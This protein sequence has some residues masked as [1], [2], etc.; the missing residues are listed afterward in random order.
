MARSFCHRSF[1]CIP[2]FC[3]VDEHEIEDPEILRALE[4]GIRLSLETQEYHPVVETAQSG[5]YEKAA[6]LV[7]EVPEIEVVVYNVQTGRRFLPLFEPDVMVVRTR[8]ESLRDEVSQGVETAYFEV[9][10]TPFSGEWFLKKR[11]DVLG[12]YLGPS[13]Y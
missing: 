9:V 5:D 8:F 6:A 2:N 12:F 10:E 3:A 13:E 1:C 4:N 7:R 11:T